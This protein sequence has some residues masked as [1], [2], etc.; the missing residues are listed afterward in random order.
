MVENPLKQEMVLLCDQLGI[1]KEILTINDNVALFFKC[2]QSFM[3]HIESQSLPKALN[4]LTE[5]SQ[6][7]YAMNLEVNLIKGDVVE[8]VYLSGFTREGNQLVIVT[9]QKNEL[10]K[11][12]EELIKINSE[13]VNQMRSVLKEKQ[14]EKRSYDNLS[15]NLFDEITQLNNELINSKRELAKK[16]TQLNKLN[17]DLE[18]LATRDPLTGLY[19]R[20]LLFDKFREEQKR[21]RRQNYPISLAVIDLNNFKKVNDQLGHLAGDELLKNFASLI[22]KMTRQD[23]DQVFR[24]GGDEFLIIFVDCSLEDAKN[25]LKRIDIALAELTDIASMAYG[26]ISV[27]HYCDKESDDVDTCILRADELMFEH[28]NA[29]KGKAKD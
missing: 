13:Q 21:S 2:E 11:L 28:K 1:I 9:N 19:N 3:Y 14:D 20:R 6:K 10:E 17:E 15:A 27:N 7:Q 23:I 18:R 16:N 24:I 26:V 22:L 8:R 4:F 5:L 25:A 29:I 12:N